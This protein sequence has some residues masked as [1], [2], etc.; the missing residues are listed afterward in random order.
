MRSP[1]FFKELG[2]TALGQILCLVHIP[3]GISGRVTTKE[4]QSNIS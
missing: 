4:R 3:F 2:V 1:E